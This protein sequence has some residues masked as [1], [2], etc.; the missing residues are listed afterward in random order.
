MY[1]ISL[2]FYR[3]HGILTRSKVTKLSSIRSE[4]ERGGRVLLKVWQ[5]T[6]LVVYIP[7]YVVGEVINRFQMKLS[8]LSGGETPR[9]VFN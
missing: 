3:L 1:L 7:V 9:E 2:L 5:N 8:T 6:K 4:A